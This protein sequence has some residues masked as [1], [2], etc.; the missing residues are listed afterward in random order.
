MAKSTKA[1]MDQAHD[2]ALTA[3]NI[4]SQ[5]KEAQR[6]QGRLSPIGTA[7]QLAS[8]QEYH[9]KVSHDL[10]PQPCSIAQPQT[11]ADGD[12]ENH[13]GGS[14]IPPQTRFKNQLK[15]KTN[16]KDKFEIATQDCCKN[17]TEMKVKKNNSGTAQTSKEET[18]AAPDTDQ[19]KNH[20]E[21]ELT[22]HQINYPS[23]KQKSNH[24]TPNKNVSDIPNPQTQ[25][26][27]QT[28]T[29]AQPNC[30]LDYY[31]KHQ[32][33]Q[34]N[35]QVTEM[36]K[37]DLI[38]TQTKKRKKGSAGESPQR[39]PGRI[40]SQQ[41]RG[42]QLKTKKKMKT[43]HS[44]AKTPI[45]TPVPPKLPTKTSP[46]LFSQHTSIAIEAL[47][48]NAKKTSDIAFKQIDKYPKK[49]P[50]H[51]LTPEK[52]R[53]AREKDNIR[54]RN[55][56]KNKKYNDAQRKSRSV[57]KKEHQSHES[58]IEML[59]SKFHQKTKQGPTF[60]CLSC[61]R[62]LYKHNVTNAERIRKLKNP[63]SKTCLRGSE[64][65]LGKQWVCLTCAKHIKNKKIPPMSVA[66]GC[67]FPYR[68]S[69]MKLNK[70]EWR[71]LAPRLVFMKIHQAPRGRQYKIEGNVVNVVAN[72]SDTVSKLPRLPSQKLTIPIK[73][74]RKSTYTHHAYSQN[75]RP[76]L[77]WKAAKWLSKHS[78]LYK[79]LNLKLTPKWKKRNMMTKKQKLTLIKSLKRK[80]RFKKK[81]NTRVK[82]TTMIHTRQK[83]KHK[84]SRT[85]TNSLSRYKA[86]KAN[87]THKATKPPKPNI[88]IAT[89]KSHFTRASK[90]RMKKPPPRGPPGTLDTML[91]A[92]GFV[93][94]AELNKILSVAPG[95]N[96]RPM[97]VFLDK[98]CE[99]L[100]YPDIFVG[101]RRQTERPTI[102]NY[103]DLVKV[104]LMNKDRRAAQNIEN[105]FF[106]TKKMQMKI[107]TGQT[108]I[109]LRRHKPNQTPTTASNFKTDDS[110]NNIIKTDQG[111]QFLKTV[112]GSP[113][114]F[115][116]AK[117]DVFAMI[118]QLGPATFFLSLSAAETKW[119]HLLKNLGKI[120]D[121]KEYTD[122]EVKQMKWPTISRLIQSDPITCARHFEY[123]LQTF[124]NEFLK[125]KTAPLGELLD[126]FYRIEMQH[127]GSCHVHMIIWIK[128]APSPSETSPK[129]LTK[130]IDKHI[131]CKRPKTE[132]SYDLI[133]RQ[134][135]HHTDTCKKNNA[136][137]CRFN[138]PQPP[139][140]RT[141]ILDPINKDDPKIKD[142]RKNWQTIKNFL[143]DYDTT[144]SMSFRTMLK[145]MKLTESEYTTAVQTSIRSKKIF[146]KRS[147]REIH[148][149]N[150]NKHTLK[151]WQANMDIQ[152][153]L[154]TYACATY[155]VQYITKGTRGL[156]KLLKDAAKEA[157]TNG[158]NIKEQMKLIS[159]RFLNSV[160]ISAQEAAY[161][162]LQ[163]P[164]KRASRAC[165]FV[166]T[167][168]P[169]DRVQLLKPLYKIK[170]M[171]DNETDLTTSNMIKRYSDRPDTL[172]GI[173]LAEWVSYYDT[174]TSYVKVSKKLQLDGTPAEIENLN[175]EVGVDD[176]QK[177]DADKP[178]KNKRRKKARIIRC[179]WFD[180]NQDEEKHYREL[181]MLFTPWRN[182]DK[183]INQDSTS[184]KEQ[185]EENKITI[186][187]LLQEYA[188][189]K[190]A[191]EEAAAAI[192]QAKA[193]GE[194]DP[195]S[196]AP[197]TVHLNEIDET[198][199]QETNDPNFVQM[200]DIGQ[201]IG[202]HLP[203]LP[204]YE[205]LKLNQIQD[206]EY[207]LSVQTLNNEQ[208]QIFDYI[209]H[210]IQSQKEQQLIFLSGGAG[211]G[212]SRTTKAIYQNLIRY[213]N[214]KEGEDYESL[215]VLV[216]APTGKAAHLI[217]G[218]TIHSALHAPF[219]S[220]SKHY[221]RASCSLL[222]T[223]R[224]HLGQV[225]FIII[226]EVSMVG[227]NRLHFVDE[228]MKEI[229]GTE[230]PFG[231]CHVLCVGDLFQLRPVADS[232]IFES[233]TYEDNN[234]TAL[235]PNLWQEHFKL[236]ELKTIMRQKENR[237][238]AEML[239]RLREG[240]QS[241]ED[242]QFMTSRVITEDF[243]H[244]NYP[245]FTVTHL[246]NTNDLVD[247]FN[248]TARTKTPV[249]II[250]RD[251]VSHVSSKESG[252][253]LLKAFQ[254]RPTKQTMGLPTKLSVAVS[255][256]VEISTNID[257]ADGLTNGASG[258]LKLLPPIPD[259]SSTMIASGTLWVL[260][261]D[262][263]IGR[264]VRSVNENL[265]MGD[266]DKNWTPIPTIKKQMKISQHS[267]I[268]ATRF[269]FPLRVA[270]GKTVHRSQGQTL[271]SAVAD[272]QHA[273][274]HHKHYVAL[275]RVT[276]PNN[277]FI[278]NFVK[279]EIRT[280]KRVT[281][282]ME[283]LR[284]NPLKIPLPFIYNHP[285]N[286]RTY[287]FHNVRTLHKH[288]NDLASDYNIMATTVL[289]VAETKLQPNTNLQP[290]KLTFPFQYHNH[291]LHT[292]TRTSAKHGTS[293]FSKHEL[294]NVAHYNT[295]TLEAT[296]AYDSETKVHIACVYRY[297]NSP[298]KQFHDDLQKLEA[299]TTT[300]QKVIIGDFNINLISKNQK[301]SKDICSSTQTRQLITTATTKQQTLIDHIY[302][303]LS[304]RTSSNVLKTYY[305]DHDQIFIQIEHTATTSIT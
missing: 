227:N 69:W 35:I 175:C 230:E 295:N 36:L 250:A 293:I 189:C 165:V 68:P 275:S 77:V 177:R 149:N 261:D 298:L 98:D 279:D 146:L 174:T 220:Q 11:V 270:A 2:Q 21:T 51:M 39:N 184:F 254:N 41:H 150:Y 100:A 233:T 116:R 299:A 128:N 274:G 81:A 148:I 143:D 44:I 153:I 74:K 137:T 176:V 123:Q 183:D 271:Q 24:K 134:R 166:N 284:Q 94:N 276:D 292:T 80:H 110:I 269:Q 161:L 212:K 65:Y 158:S 246:F 213:Y 91:T 151:A 156:S 225:E 199:P 154:D 124:V 278:T 221:M 285:H 194:L 58:K 169:E 15:N 289:C 222:N 229:K 8:A 82:R 198:N 303:N 43:T 218:V 106:K 62:L 291:P 84:R 268:T 46:S 42:Q 283:R 70:M 281:D 239:N 240:N 234:P 99:E 31:F 120:V 171:E 130:Y 305:S 282:E 28:S 244:F 301:A 121:K 117:K 127:R 296:T 262:V 245:H 231:G 219:N 3:T 228:R 258:V 92:D 257:I 60:I 75:I 97:S 241:D 133:M 114:Y 56:R 297:P 200:Y 197:L 277:L 188:P 288:C 101:Q 242:I 57:R 96:Q 253:Q 207:R 159:N 264:N 103:S 16:Q 88:C 163:M 193:D 40:E 135:H 232:W 136:S 147:L 192:E 173:T 71:L 95:E 178:A 249:H 10:I 125:S 23:L 170:Q 104:E 181:L 9:I 122:K 302:T 247:E 55:A 187:A 142:H 185:Y 37:D 157:K 202:V 34:S 217:G 108:T 243:R 267:T 32:A 238:F 206:H 13:Q 236:Y 59:I 215:K 255:D 260:F 79:E 208:R 272:F 259:D 4:K 66:N 6:Q 251:S 53:I 118:R 20:P 140:E 223:L 73:L 19:Y 76:N 38:T 256:R 1:L 294:H 49:T 54:K 29:Y 155:V 263:N 113:P 164:L 87:L 107:I 25:Q 138:Y 179:P 182:E 167:S 211:V 111:Y 145:T 26:T 30:H 273:K 266:I 152:F 64:E 45:T 139:M 252:L 203:N 72:I 47:K 210:S 186:T 280:D 195:T 90:I 196:I 105:L 33:E 214:Y 300:D 205:D 7:T 18:Y 50:R 216:M 160:E 129:A 144:K 126:F 102:V 22:K 83:G 67:T 226:D 224:T 132:D 248:L 14:S 27:K 12:D 109:A 190:S 112:R 63:V 287:T 78:P 89:T 304:I 286:T 85:R 201:D 290:L 131:T 86:L 191:L 209:S 162:A 237:A 52:L 48:Q 61:K 204:K 235:A 180:K 115:E 141:T 119:T 265:Y 168:P 172:E 93:E 5:L 17:P